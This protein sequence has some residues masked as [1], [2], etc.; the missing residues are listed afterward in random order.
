MAIVY[1]TSWEADRSDTYD[2]REFSQIA[3]VIATA[4]ETLTPVNI[5]TATH[6][7]TGAVLPDVGSQSDI[8][9][10]FYVQAV[11]PRISGPRFASVGLSY[12]LGKGSGEQEEED[13]L[14]N[15]V[16]Y[17][18][19][20]GVSGDTTDADVNGNPL[21]N[22][23]GDPFNGTVQ[24][25]IAAIYVDVIRN[26]SA[27]NLPNAIGYTNKVNEDNFTLAGYPINPGEAYCLG[28]QPEGDYKLNDDYVTIVYSFEIRERY[29]L[30]NGNRVTAFIHRLLD[31]GK[32]GWAYGEDGGEEIGDICPKNGGD[33]LPSAVTSDVVLDGQGTPL[34]K[35]SYV[36][37][38]PNFDQGGGRGWQPQAAPG[39]APNAVRDVD[40]N[41]AATFLL[42]EKYL[43]ATMGGLGLP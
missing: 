1:T 15:P 13:P 30:Q 24:T 20:N 29:T 27:Y 4:G 11:R 37:P 38:N 16:R 40:P 42:Y 12:R 7:T 21:L 3:T 32:R 2:S 19:R 28:I 9:S 26:E 39:K 43:T 5:K 18:I 25:N 36:T 17:R 8:D 23:A 10:R 35:D 14:N 33:S 41:T 22:S 6:Q 34:E 31:Q